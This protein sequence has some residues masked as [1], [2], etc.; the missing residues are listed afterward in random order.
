[1]ADL[2]GGKRKLN[3]RAIQEKYEILKEIKKV[4]SAKE[5]GN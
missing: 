3:T 1:M 2:A 5:V 4:L